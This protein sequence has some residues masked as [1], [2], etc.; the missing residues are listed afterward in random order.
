MS[1]DFVLTADDISYISNGRFAK[2][3][4]ESSILNN[5]QV[6]INN[7]SN[8]QRYPPQNFTDDILPIVIQRGMIAWYIVK[9]GIFT[10]TVNSN[11]TIQL[12][13]GSPGHITATFT[14]PGERRDECDGPFTGGSR[15]RVE[16]LLDGPNNH[17]GD[18]YLIYVQDC[19]R[20]LNNISATFVR[21]LPAPLKIQLINNMTPIN[22]NNQ[23]FATLCWRSSIIN[24]TVSVDNNSSGF[25]GNW[26][27]SDA[28]ITYILP[29][30]ARSEGEALYH[31]TIGN[32]GYTVTKKENNWTIELDSR[33]QGQITVTF[34]PS[35]DPEKRPQCR[36]FVQGPPVFPD[37]AST[38]ATFL[39]DG[40][41]YKKGDVYLIYVQDCC[42]QLGLFIK[43]LP[44]NVPL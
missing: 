18:V 44:S 32:F 29:I 6:T 15:T 30:T 9:I 2:A 10:Y 3:C 41:N 14:T 20:N 12:N 13:Q 4:I 31:V 26:Q 17:K 1:R 23:R 25:Y 8:W 5:S 39:F 21:F 37:V 42:M 24:T 7:G 43:F 16:F 19:C 34:I 11:L 38:R 35:D 27:R 33:S 40:P 36:Q 22:N 28:T